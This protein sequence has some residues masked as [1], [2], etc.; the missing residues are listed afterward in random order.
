LS[1][2]LHEM[3]AGRARVVRSG[4][5]PFASVRPPLGHDLATAFGRHA[6]AKPVTAL[7]YQLARLVGPLHA[8][9]SAGWYRARIACARLP[10][11]RN[12]DL[13]GVAAPKIWRLIR[14]RALARQCKQTLSDGRERC[15]GASQKTVRHRLPRKLRL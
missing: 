3:E 4:A 7:A 2:P 11:S 1:Q 13:Q 8:S 10:R 12:P 9:F 6:G 15:L 14:E 5:E